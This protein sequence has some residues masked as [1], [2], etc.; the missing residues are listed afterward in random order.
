MWQML[1][2]PDLTSKKCVKNNVGIEILSSP[3]LIISSDKYVNQIHNWFSFQI[4]VFGMEVKN[5]KLLRKVFELQ[6]RTVL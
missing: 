3:E 2:A 1:M 4:T 6:Y 5:V